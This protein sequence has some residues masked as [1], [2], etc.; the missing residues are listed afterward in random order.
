MLLFD[1]FV[2]VYSELSKIPDRQELLLWL[3]GHETGISTYAFRCLTFRISTLVCFKLCFIST[4]LV[5]LVP[6]TMEYA[7]LVAA[8]F[9]S[10]SSSQDT[11]WGRAMGSSGI[12]GI[13]T[14]SRTA[15][16][17]LTIFRVD[18]NP[19]KYIPLTQIKCLPSSIPL[20]QIP[21]S[22]AVHCLVQ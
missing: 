19:H 20:C 3:G 22:T 16:D 5:L 8:G 15:S 12:P 4:T 21:Q 7:H 14:S 6:G 9:C 13:H 2:I 17:M 18:R 11:E 1:A 10:A